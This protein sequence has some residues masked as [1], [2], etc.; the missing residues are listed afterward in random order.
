M[1][2]WDLAFLLSI[3]NLAFRVRK[4][5]CTMPSSNRKI[6]DQDR[7]HGQMGIF[8]EP[9]MIPEREV[10]RWAGF[11][12]TAKV[13][14][15]GDPQ[16]LFPYWKNPRPGG[17]F[18][19]ANHGCY[20][21][22]PFILLVLSATTADAVVIISSLPQINPN[23]QFQVIWWDSV[24]AKWSRCAAQDLA[25]VIQPLHK[26]K[27]VLHLRTSPSSSPRSNAEACA[28]FCE[29]AKHCCRHF[30]N[31]FTKKTW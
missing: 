17:R 22:T 4:W 13:A 28:W 16:S 18:P 6:A 23:S 9:W 21:R 29:I 1:H 3:L 19:A 11:H 26:L 31:L 25:L 20:W 7:D 30:I 15:G 12:W 27:Q 14:L 24:T 8:C 10:L 5:S 2:F